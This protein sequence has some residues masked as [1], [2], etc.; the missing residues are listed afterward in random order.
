MSQM[1]VTPELHE[2][3]LNDAQKNEIYNMLLAN[4]VS[5]EEAVNELK[6]Y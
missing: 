2:E 1:S 6:K 4:G 3:S 5:H